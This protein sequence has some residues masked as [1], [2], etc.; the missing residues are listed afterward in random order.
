MPRHTSAPRVRIYVVEDD[1]DISRLMSLHLSAAGY[2]PEQFTHG[3]AALTAAEHA[4]PAMVLLDIRLPDCDGREVARRLRS[5]AQFAQTAIM[6][7]SAFSTE[8]DRV[9]A[10]ES[11]ADDYLV[12][13]FSPRELVARVTAILRRFQPPGEQ[14]LRSGEVEINVTSMMVAVRGQAVA[15]TAAEFRLL[16]FF[17]EHPNMVYSREQLLG[18]IWQGSRVVI[19]RT[20]DVHVRRIRAKVEPDPDH[21][22]YLL[23][24]RGSGYR[25]HHPE[26]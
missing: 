21:P 3:V 20:V 8:T 16:R 5:S 6:M 11:G 13:P 15:T 18:V 22:T 23:T 26:T 19:P 9:N 12:K 14:L 25:W 2:Q 7:V 24:V 4:A 17:V 10:L 1:P